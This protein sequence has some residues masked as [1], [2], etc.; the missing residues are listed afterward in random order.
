ML[1]IEVNAIVPLL[2]TVQQVLI[3]GSLSMSGVS[4]PDASPPTQ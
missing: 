1:E 3:E 2:L 4:N